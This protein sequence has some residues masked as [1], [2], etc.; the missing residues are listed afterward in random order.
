MVQKCLLSGYAANGVCEN[1]YE[2]CLRFLNGKLIYTTDE[3]KQIVLPIATLK[4]PFSGEFDLSQCGDTG[5]DLSVNTGCRKGKITEN[6]NKVEIWF[7]PWFSVEKNLNST[8]PH[9]EPIF[10]NWN[11]TVAP[12]GIFWNWGNWDNLD[13]YDYLTT[14][15]LNSISSDNLL[16]L[17]EKSAA[18]DTLPLNSVMHRITVLHGK[19]FMFILTKIRN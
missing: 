7:T 13:W 16:K 3:G 17:Y 19:N 5:K 15:D 4:N 18:P 11:H 9:L 1:D 12:I 10:T 14:C 6:G 2:N 8:A